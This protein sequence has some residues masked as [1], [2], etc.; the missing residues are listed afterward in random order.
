[1]A[2]S[3]ILDPGIVLGLTLDRYAELLRIPEAAFNGL[4]K[5][6]DDQQFACN[7]I[8]KQYNRDHLATYLSAAEE[9]RETEIKF[10]ISK[11][12][13]EEDYMYKSYLYN[14]NKAHLAI[15]GEQT[16]TVIS[17]ETVTYRD[18]YA[19]IID[20][21]IL[22]IAT[23]VT[24]TDEL[25]VYYPGEDVEIHPSNISISGGVATIKIPR[26][27]L[28]KPELNDNRD[29]HLYY[30]TDTNFLETV[31]VKRVYYNETEGVKLVWLNCTTGAEQTQRAK[32]EID[33]Y[34]N[35]I[36]RVAPA[37]YSNGA[38][39][40][41]AFMYAGS[42]HKVRVRY[43]SGKIQS[44]NTQLLTLRLAHALMPYKPID[45]ESVTQYWQNDAEIGSRNPM[46]PYGNKNGAVECWVADSRVK[47]GSGGM[48]K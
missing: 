48:F 44:M 22:T 36:I 40:Y 47:K 13:L 30:E 1:M 6:D 21:I 45:C 46:T 3:D 29:D 38:W 42:P 9:R 25:K 20:P 18:I 5:S 15:V 12:Y 39:A 26:S 43:L 28:V 24:D 23:T 19:A 2:R 8:W 10:N 16:T 7:T 4:N 41:T 37:N 31:D 33:D 34:E 11:K 35:S 32:S 17:T 27:R 14:L